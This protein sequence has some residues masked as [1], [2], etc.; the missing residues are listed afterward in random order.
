ML[1]PL[2]PHG[3]DKFLGTMHT[4]PTLADARKYLTSEWKGAHAPQELPAGLECF[5]A[6]QRD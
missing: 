4:Y 2:G 6:Q 3:K 5:D 1:R